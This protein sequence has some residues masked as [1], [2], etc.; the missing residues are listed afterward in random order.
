MLITTSP[1]EKVVT[2][3]SSFRNFPLPH[4]SNL[5][6]EAFQFRPEKYTRSY[7]ILP[8]WVSWFVWLFLQLRGS[9]LGPHA[10]TLPLNYIPSLA[11]FLTGEYTQAQSYNTSPR[12]SKYPDFWFPGS[13]FPPSVWPHYHQLLKGA[14]ISFKAM[15]FLSWKRACQLALRY[16]LTF[17]SL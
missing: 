1:E 7:L 10:S 14:C 12:W 3:V 5:F 17:S 13:I 4:V 11:P 9:N 8:A 16:S 2:I 15:N 6:S